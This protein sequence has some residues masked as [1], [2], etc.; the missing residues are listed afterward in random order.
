MTFP[1]TMDRTHRRIT[2]AAIV[3]LAG[4]VAAILA[5][6]T[7]PPVPLPVTR[8][9]VPTVLV[10]VVV[11]L[12]VAGMMAPRAVELSG[13]TLRIERRAWQPLVIRLVDVV[14]VERGP[15]L[16]MFR[17]LRLAGV[18]GFFGS[19]GLFW[20]RGIGKHRLYATRLGP[21][22]LVRR[23]TAVPVV[24]A[25]DD[26]ESLRAAIAERLGAHGLRSDRGHPASP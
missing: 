17:S 2:L 22:V 3:A 10:L 13:S 26:A 15:E 20:T 6:S 1:M 16:G 11:P 21:S 14:A 8:Y 7:L 12:T 9:L 18:G 24:I 5:G 4:V 25:P 19:Y 23:R